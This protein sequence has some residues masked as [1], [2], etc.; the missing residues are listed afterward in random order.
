MFASDGA[1]QAH[2]FFQNIGAKGFGLRPLPVDTAVE[3]NQR[4]HIA[5]ARMEHIDALQAVVLLFGGDKRQ[6]P[7]DVAARDGAVHTVIIRCQLCSGGKSVFAP[8]PHRQPLDFVARHLNADGAALIQHRAHAADFFGHFFGRAVR[9]AQQN[10]FGAQV[11]AHFQIAVDRTG[12]GA[13]HHFQ[14]SRNN[15]RRHHRR[16]G[17]A[18][19]AHVVEAGHN[20]L[21]QLRLGHKLHHHFGNH[22][23][24]AFAADKHG[25]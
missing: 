24:H 5:V 7:A 2:A 8:G 16:H 20:H 11:V 23:K 13:V 17:I 9:F 18:R 3:Q 15:P 12:A 14:P 6:H 25:E 4:V 19:F 10:G 22:R 1:A 21:R